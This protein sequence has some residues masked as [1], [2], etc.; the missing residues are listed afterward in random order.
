VRGA[1][2]SLGLA[3]DDDRT[4]W[5]LKQVQ[6]LS[7]EAKRVISTE[8]LL[9]FYHRFSNTAKPLNQPLEMKYECA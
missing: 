3:F 1:L 4:Q 5:V 9:D 8:E 2:R 7:I 6:E